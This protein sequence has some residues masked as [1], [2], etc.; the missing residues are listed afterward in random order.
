MV[1]GGEQKV[2]DAD[3]VQGSA[4]TSGAV[5]ANDQPIPEAVDAKVIE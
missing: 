2:K 4:M 3:S 1:G 5:V